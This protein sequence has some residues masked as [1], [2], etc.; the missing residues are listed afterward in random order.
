MSAAPTT[1]WGGSLIGSSITRQ[2]STRNTND[3]DVQTHSPEVFDDA[4]RTLARQLSR[5]S[6]A[7]RR[8][9]EPLNPFH[10]DN[11]DSR[12]DPN[13]KEF[14]AEAWSRSMMAVHSRDPERYPRRTAGVSFT[15]LNI[16]GFGSPTDF[17]KTVGNVWLDYVGRAKR[18]IG[19][20]TRLTKLN[21]LRNFDGLL[22]AGEMLIVLGRPGRCVS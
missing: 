10:P 16:H 9:T 2:M 4:V 19:L 18:L 6:A 5:M 15:N 13:S 17:Q 14:S 7:S 20:G 12:L 21:I 11:L 1:P 22:K 8:D 3:P